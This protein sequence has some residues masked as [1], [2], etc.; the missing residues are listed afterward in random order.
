MVTLKEIKKRVSSARTVHKITKALKIVSAAKARAAQL[1]NDASRPYS[2]AIYKLVADLWSITDPQGHPLLAQNSSEKITY[3]LLASDRGL[4]GSFL[5]NLERFIFQE[6]IFSNKIDQFIVVGKRGAEILR[7]QGQFPT[8]L[9]EPGTRQPL[10]EFVNPIVRLFTEGYLSG[11]CGQVVVI[12]T[13]YINSF[14]QKPQQRRILPAAKLEGQKK[15][16]DTALYEPSADVVLES[17]LP[18]YLEVQLYQLILESFASEHAARMV[19]MEKATEGAE[20]I[21]EELALS[22]NKIRQEKITSEL[23]EINSALAAL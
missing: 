7:H 22:Y 8:A 21:I 2:D 4:C 14:L 19:A 3:M 18:R 12:Y 13:S 6:K 11:A 17:L 1:A 15:P 16:S 20:E 9:F 5:T 10:F 23:L